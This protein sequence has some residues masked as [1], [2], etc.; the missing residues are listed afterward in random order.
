MKATTPDIESLMTQIIAR[1]IAAGVELARSL[2]HC[3]PA[4][5]DVGVRFI[6]AGEVTRIRMR[7]DDVTYD[8]IVRLPDLEGHQSLRV[9][10]AMWE[11]AWGRIHA[12]ALTVANV[13][14]DKHPEAMGKNAA[15][16]LSFLNQISSDEKLY[17]QWMA[18]CRERSVNFTY[19]TKSR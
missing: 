19:T 16:A 3:M 1:D 11:V 18:A 6:A 10:A 4:A 12:D 9:T 7:L 5:F 13:W 17:M 2:G 8:S 15:Q 14:L